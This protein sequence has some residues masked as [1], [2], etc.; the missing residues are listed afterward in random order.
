MESQR[1]YHQGIEY[2][3]VLLDKDP[4]ADLA[5][6]NLGQ[7]LSCIG[8]YDDALSAYEYSF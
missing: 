2:L 4:Y 5:W 6:Y 8:E 7:A 1:S 3:K